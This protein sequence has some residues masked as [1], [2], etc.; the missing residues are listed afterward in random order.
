[1]GDFRKRGPI[2]LRTYLTN[3]KVGDIVD[4]KGTGTVQLG[5]PYKAY[6]GKTGRV[7][8][9]TKRA[10]GVVVNKRIK[11]RIV[12]KHLNV[13]IE[14]VKHSK[15]RQDFVKR[16][17]SNDAM[18][19]EAKAKGETVDLRRQPAGPRP[20][21]FVNFASNPPVTVYPRKFEFL[22]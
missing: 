21:E 14:H 9:V 1:M 16:V 11:N 19:K 13:R 22:A 4:I 20:A 8:N 12:R 10:V 3:Y 5:M 18:K 17:K 7:Y 2:N 15:C 6:H